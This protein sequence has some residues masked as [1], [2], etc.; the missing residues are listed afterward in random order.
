MVLL[1]FTFPVR[2]TNFKWMSVV[3][4]IVPFFA[5]LGMTTET[6]LSGW[7]EFL[8]V[9]LWRFAGLTSF[10]LYLNLP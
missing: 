9:Y 3:M 8:F 4:S 10:L 5:A 7:A 2:L 6:S 1:I